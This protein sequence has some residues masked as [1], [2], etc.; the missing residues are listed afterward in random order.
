MTKPLGRAAWRK[1]FDKTWEQTW[2][3]VDEQIW[4]LAERT[5]WREVAHTLPRWETLEGTAREQLTND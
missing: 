5:L 2:Y 1:V 4:L 3:S